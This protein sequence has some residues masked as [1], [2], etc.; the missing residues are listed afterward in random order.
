MSLAL[1]YD[2]TEA[3]VADSVERYC[4]DRWSD[5]IR[6][7]ATDPLPPALWTGLADLGVFALATGEL[8]GGARAMCAATEALGK[9]LFPGP[10][11]ATFLGSRVCGEP[12]RSE[13]AGGRALVAVGRPPLLPWAARAR[14]F[15]VVGDGSV[16]QATARGSVAPVDTLAGEPWGR[17]EV[18][19]GDVVE[20]AGEGSA[21]YDLLV[22]AYLAAAAAS[23]LDAAV[24]HARTRKQFGHAIGDFQAIAHPL[25]ECS[26]GLAAA[27]SLARAAA[28]R[29][30][31]GDD[32]AGQAAGGARLSAERA[33]LATVQVAHQTF[34]A[35]GVTEEGP[36]VS[37]SRKIRQLVALPTAV[38]SPYDA[39]FRL[40]LR[41]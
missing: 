17:V 26:M 19:A 15:L 2:A 38:A 30:D 14:Y 34:G 8:D 20:R 7:R 12:A 28:Y 27:T 22:A 33:A 10:L 32:R 37:F 6:R 36:A 13:I 3:A 1:R 29:L 21:L 9:A 41:C 39:A 40:A 35:I 31:V 25:A 23:L 4:R 5:A 16:R 24:E 11:A 18:E